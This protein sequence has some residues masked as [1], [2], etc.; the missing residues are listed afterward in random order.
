M[1]TL[2][3]IKT[4][5]E[6]IEETYEFTLAYAAQGLDGSEGKKAGSE[7]RTYLTKADEAIGKLVPSF[8][9]VVTSN[10]LA[11]AEQYNAFVDIIAQDAQ[12][13]SAGVKLVLAQESISSQLIDNLNASIHVRALLTDLFLIEEILKQA[14]AGST[15]NES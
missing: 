13:T 3:D 2:T 4:Y 6:L 5:I 12:A 10:Q 7:I 11:P 9:E 14:L 1:T 8:R 15:Q